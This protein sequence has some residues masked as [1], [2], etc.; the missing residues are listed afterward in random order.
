MDMNMHRQSRPA[1][2]GERPVLVTGAAGFLGSRVVH[3]LSAAGRQVIAT[4]IVDGERGKA[5]AELPGVTFAAAE[6]RD[7]EAVSELVNQCDHLVHLAAMRRRASQQGGQIPFDV[8]V[9]ATY[10]LLGAAATQPL[11]G[12]VYGSSHL[13]YGDF[14]DPG[15]WFSETDATPG[16]GLSLYAAAKLASE[17]FVAAFSDEFGFEYLCLRFGGIY[18]PQAAPGSNTS[19]MTDV[20]ASLDRGERPIVDWSSDT[21]H[22]MIHVDDAARA[23][24]TALEF[25]VSACSINVVNPPSTA[26]AIYSELVSLYGG[27]PAALTWTESKTRFQQVRN[28][29]L[30]YD[31]KCP[32]ATTLTAGLTSIIDWHRQHS[33]GIS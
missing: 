16:P 22:C 17:A 31:L 27:D 3:R 30:L 15:R 24:V 18:G 29:R 5:L 2:S 19:V 13:V 28:E 4:D 8:N 9:A 32:P 25:P 26:E 23:V 1:T 11:K 12:V 14:T 33:T 10:A 20:L 7:G 6:L 21:T